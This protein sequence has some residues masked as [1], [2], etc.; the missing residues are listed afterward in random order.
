MKLGIMPRIYSLVLYDNPDDID[1]TSSCQVFVFGE[2]G[3]MFSIIGKGFYGHFS[4]DKNIDEVFNKLEITSLEGVV[5]A[6]HLKLLR[7]VLKKTSYGVVLE[8]K[9]VKINNRYLHWI[10]IFKKDNNG[11]PTKL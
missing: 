2:R 6:S 4:N 1:Y 7:M 8:D 9:L 5:K 3:Y 11:I 10:K